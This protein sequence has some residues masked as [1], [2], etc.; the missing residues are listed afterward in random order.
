LYINSQNFF[1]PLNYTIIQFIILT[2]YLVSSVIYKMRKLKK[3]TT[4]HTQKKTI[5]K[6][7]K[8]I[9]TLIKTTHP[10]LK[11]CNKQDP[12]NKKREEIKQTKKIS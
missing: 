6:K 8:K 5:T 12:L 1:L 4:K 2:K 7:N 10:T 11:T 9:L 3:I